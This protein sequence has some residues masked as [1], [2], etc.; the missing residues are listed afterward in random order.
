MSKPRADGLPVANIDA[1][2]ASDAFSD[3]TNQGDRFSAR[4]GAVGRALQTK[5]L[6]VT[7]TVVPAGKRAWPRHYHYANDEL[8][9]VL[10]GSGALHY[11]EKSGPIREGD[12]VY[13]EAGTG[14]PFQIENDSDA[15]LKYLA[16]DA[17]IHPDVFVYPDSGKVGF[18]AGGPPLR[19]GATPTPKLVRFFADAAKTGYWDGELED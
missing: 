5:K 2:L 6:G 8:F 19:E 14:V 9:I 10:E 3:T 18:V 4:F 11:G 17:Q 16:V 12:I 7:V 1:V 13:I 15:E